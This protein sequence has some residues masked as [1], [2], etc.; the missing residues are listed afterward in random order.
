[1]YWPLTAFNGMQLPVPLSL[2]LLLVGVPLQSGVE[3]PAAEPKGPQVRFEK[4]V[5]EVWEVGVFWLA[6]VARVLALR[7]RRRVVIGSCIFLIVCCW[8]VDSG[9][10]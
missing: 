3:K 9:C 2:T 6:G 5:V 1:M 4:G 10:L 7:A 8:V